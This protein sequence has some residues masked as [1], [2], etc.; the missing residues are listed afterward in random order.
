MT[1]DID[2]AY[3]NT[4]VRCV[5]GSDMVYLSR[6]KDVDLVNSK[7]VFFKRKSYRGACT[8]CARET[9]IE[10]GKWNAEISWNRETKAEL[11]KEE[12]KE[13]NDGDV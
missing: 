2:V 10:I 7:G 4:L 12:E 1:D 8:E 13:S 3:D 5:C 9:S 11:K 6:E